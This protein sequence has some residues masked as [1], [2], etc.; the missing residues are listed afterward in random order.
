MPPQLSQLHPSIETSLK[1]PTFSDPYLSAP[2]DPDEA[3]FRSSAIRLTPVPDGA[4]SPCPSSDLHGAPSL[5]TASVDQSAFQPDNSNPSVLSPGD[6]LLSNPSA[7]GSPNPG[8]GMTG[9]NLSL[10]PA[11]LSNWQPDQAMSHNTPDSIQLSSPQPILP[12]AQLL[13][14]ILTD[15]PSPTSDVTSH[16]FCPGSD[17][18]LSPESTQNLPPLITSPVSDALS[19]HMDPDSARARSPI[20]MVESVSRGDS[21]VRGA[22]YSRR[23]SSAYLS[24]GDLDSDDDDEMDDGLSVVS[25]TADGSW[26]RDTTTGQ[27]GVDPTSR[28][29]MRWRHIENSEKRMLSSTVGPPLSARPRV[30]RGVT[31]SLGLRTEAENTGRGIVA[32][33]R[34][35]VIHPYNKIISTTG[36]S[37]MTRP[38]LDR[39]SWSRRRAM[40]KSPANS[41]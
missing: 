27:A 8:H 30:R 9:L 21:P 35:Q 37:S 28:V 5:D 10:N 15:N 17:A 22:N 18:L 12:S 31:S 41:N 7:R 26:V 39:A 36:L 33:Q 14:P 34:V 16:S 23:P 19:V 29:R 25:R 38:S 40:M 4:S 20:V 2:L 24:P 11:E 32:V 3:D 6:E 1:D 13:S